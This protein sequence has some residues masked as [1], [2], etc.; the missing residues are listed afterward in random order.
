MTHSTRRVSNARYIRLNWQL[1]LLLLPAVLATLLFKYVPMGGLF[2]AFQDFNIFD[3]IWDS[4]FAGMKHFANLLTDR[5]FLLT[6]R[7]SF[8]ISFYKLLFIFPLPILLAILLN[9]VRLLPYKKLV[10]TTAY[11]PHFLSWSIVYGVFYTLLTA[12]GPVNDLRHFL[13]LPR[14]PYFVTAS[15]FRSVLVFTDAWKT[16]GWGCIVYLA[17]L[18]SI[19]PQQYEAARIDGAGKLRQICHI[20]LP[21]IRSTVVIMLILRLGSLISAGFEQVFIM[22]NP[23]VYDVADILDT[24]VYRTGLGQQNFSY[25]SAVGLFNSLVSLTL[26]LSSNWAAKRW[27]GH[28]MW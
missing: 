10:Q 25:A 27:F 17:A 4:P 24:Y 3:G 22:Y 21:G 15:A 5:Y 20:T 11:L 23:T 14:V 7:N 18:T 12:N 26:V 6:L 2:I 16:V 8:I 13:G 28:S 19:D 1:Y 9:E